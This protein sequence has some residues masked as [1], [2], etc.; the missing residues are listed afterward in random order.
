M[1][2]REREKIEQRERII[3]QYLGLKTLFYYLY[4]SMHH[5]IWGEIVK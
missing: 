1:R 5:A 4:E 3:P 2:A